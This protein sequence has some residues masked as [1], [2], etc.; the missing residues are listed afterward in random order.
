MTDDEAGA[1]DP[2]ELDYLQARL[3]GQLEAACCMPLA[4]TLHQHP[5]NW[6]NS[7]PLR[8]RFGAKVIAVA[9]A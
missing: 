5:E 7:Q 6:R 2:E 3:V 8:R 9:I 4:W 1:L